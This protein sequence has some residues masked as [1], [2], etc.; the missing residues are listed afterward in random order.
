MCYREKI[1]TTYDPDEIIIIGIESVSE[2]V[3]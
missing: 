1:T 3:L 2:V